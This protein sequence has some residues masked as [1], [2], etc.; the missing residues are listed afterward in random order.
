MS[1]PRRITAVLLLLVAASALGV[2]AC[3][4]DSTRPRG[5]A[6]PVIA[7]DTTRPVQPAA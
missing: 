1:A 7:L 5:G 3:E 4:V 2:P 6:N